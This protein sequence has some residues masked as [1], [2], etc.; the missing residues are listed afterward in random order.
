MASELYNDGKHQCIGFC[1]L[2]LNGGIQ[3]NQYL[4]ID[5]NHCALIDPGGELIYKDLLMSSSEYMHGKTLDYVISSHQYPDI[6]SSLTEWLNDSESTIV[7][8]ILWERFVTDYTNSNF[9]H[10]IIGIPDAGTKI[11]LGDSELIAIPAHFL[12]A[13]GNFQFYD[14]ISKILFSGDMGASLFLRYSDDVSQPVEDF[15]TYVFNIESFHRRYMSCNKVC[16][17]WVN[18]VRELDVEW[19]VPHN[20]RCFKGK[21]MVERFLKWLE[22]LQCGTDL[23]TQDTYKVP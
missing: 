10:R 19:I 7:V 11:Q 8:S 5:G 1:D 15:D 9:H 4:V 18:M 2:T 14:P 21:A 22:E 12:H 20:G 13:D 16:R 6:L 3:S 17:Y 23:V